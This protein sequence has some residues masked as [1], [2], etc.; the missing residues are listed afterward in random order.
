MQMLFVDLTDITASFDCDDRCRTEA[1][2][3]DMETFADLGWLSI[4]DDLAMDILRDLS[5]QILGHHN[6]RRQLFGEE[7][8]A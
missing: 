8:R 5:N 1:T 3:S 7:F 6:T 4:G 2:S